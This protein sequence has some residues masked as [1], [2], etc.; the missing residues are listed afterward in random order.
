[1]LRDYKKIARLSYIL[2]VVAVVL[3]ALSVVLIVTDSPESRSVSIPAGSTYSLRYNATVDQGDYLFYSVVANDSKANFTA[4]LLAPT[5]S[6]IAMGNFS[7]NGSMKKDI[8]A[9]EAGNWTLIV[10]NNA[11]I[12]IFA[13]LS[14]Y[15]I[16]YMATYTIVFGLTLFASGIILLLVSVNLRKRENSFSRRQRDLE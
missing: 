14:I 16:S 3:L 9:G 11:N 13:K 7:G 12:N 5:G 4:Y 15:K 6:K 10:K 8:V 2:I 1:V